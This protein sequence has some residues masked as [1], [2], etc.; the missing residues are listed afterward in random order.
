MRRKDREI[1]DKTDMMEI[2]DQSDVCRIAFVTGAAPYIVPL[3]Y[4]YRWE[5]GNTGQ[6]GAL[7][8]YFHCAAEGRK[9][10]LMR[11]DNRV[12]FEIDTAHELITNPQACGWGMKYKSLIGSGRLHVVKDFNEKRQY[13]DRIMLHYGF[14]GKTHY[15]DSML[16]KTTV[17]KL[18][19]SELSGKEKKR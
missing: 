16:E 11:A 5:D 13:L 2:L 18:E 19:V 9:L 17:L 14:T 12:G 4:G 6:P 10:D 1:N 7:E 15:E 3:N 8:L